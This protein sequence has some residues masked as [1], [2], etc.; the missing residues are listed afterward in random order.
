[1]NP[2]LLQ[3]SSDFMGPAVN[4]ATHFFYLF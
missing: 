1:V 3:G 4:S 2:T